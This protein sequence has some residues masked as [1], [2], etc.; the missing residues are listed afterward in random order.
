M[1]ENNC[2]D[3]SSDKLARLHKRRRR[4]ENKE[5]IQNKTSKS[6]NNC[7]K[8]HRRITYALVKTDN[9]Q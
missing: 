7:T 8:L 3:I 6:T 2:I 9:T 4:H 1:E 5:Q